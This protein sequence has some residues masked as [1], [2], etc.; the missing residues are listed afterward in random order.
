VP[1]NITAPNDPGFAT[2]V[3]N[4]TATA[5]DNAGPVTPNCSPQSGTAFLIG[6]TTVTCTATD[7]SGNTASGSFLVAVVDT[8]PPSLTVPANTTVNANS[9]SGAVVTFVTTATD[10]APG[11]TKACIPTS[12]STFAVGA[13]TVNCI[14]TDVAGNATSKSFQITVV[15]AVDQLN[16]LINRVKGMTIEPGFKSELLNRLNAALKAV[17]GNSN[18]KACQ[19]L[20]K[21]LDGVNSKSGKKILA[22]NAATLT[23][24]ANRIR[25]VLAC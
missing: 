15:G 17:N 4:Y 8:E 25:S 9:P 13:T 22:A 11:V 20:A 19:E 1:A 21:F 12:G 14:A 3:V 7:G 10:N 24:D 16:D 5:T 18:G 2:A 6:T 23:A